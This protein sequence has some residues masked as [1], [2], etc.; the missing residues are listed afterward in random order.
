MIPISGLVLVVPRA[1][2]SVP[3]KNDLLYEDAGDRIRTGDIRTGAE[4]RQWIESNKR[5]VAAGVDL[6]D[7]KSERV[8]A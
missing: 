2:P 1:M 7:P 8:V 6:R 5:E 3:I 4:T